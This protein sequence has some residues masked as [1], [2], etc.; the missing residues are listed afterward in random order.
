MPT[1]RPTYRPTDLPT[2][3]PITHPPPPP[4]Q[5][6]GLGHEWSGR[7]RPDGTSPPQAPTNVDA[8]AYIFDRF[9]TLVGGDYPRYFNDTRFGSFNRSSS[10]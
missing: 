10:R 8:T 9:S 5:V 2:N 3:Q 6:A 7:P 4:P 1:E